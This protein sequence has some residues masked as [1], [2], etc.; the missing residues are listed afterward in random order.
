MS[1]FELEFHTTW[2]G[3]AQP[4]EGLVVSPPVLV[5]AQC[6]QKQ[7]PEMQQRLLS[8]C[9]LKKP[10]EGGSPAVTD[11]GRALSELLELSPDLFDGAEALPKELH[12]FVQEGRQ[13]LRPT[14]GL[15]RQGAPTDAPAVPT[16]EST[17]ASRAGAD[18]LMLVW[19]VPQGLDL[20]QSETK[21]GPWDYPAQAKFDRL[22]R[23]CRVPIGLLFNGEEFRLTYAP[24]GE[25]TGWLSFRV[26]D[27]CTVGGRPLL[28]AFVMLLSAFRWFGAAPDQ[29]LPALL[30]QSR[31]RQ[32]GVT[33]E[34][35]RQVF[36]ALE[37]LLAGFAAAAE[38][39]GDQVLRRALERA[40]GHVYSGLLT[41]LLRLV[42][43]LYCEDGNLL[44]TDNKLFSKHY[45]VLG[46][47]D[48]LQKD[49]GRYPDSMA[50][51]FGAY[52]RLVSL[53]R[54][55]FL[56]A[57]H[58][59]LQLPER[60]GHLFDPSEFPFLE[61]WGADGSAPIS[62]AESREATPV[63][64]VDDGTIYQVLER[65]VLLNGQ[66]LSYKA[67]DVEQIGSVY[68]ALMGFDVE[69]LVSG[70]VRIKPSSKKGAARV[71]V[72]AEALLAVPA[73]RRAKWLQDELAF[74]K[75]MANKIAKAVSKAQTPVEA[76]QAL[77][78]LSGRRPERAAAGTLVIQP[79]LERRRTSSHYTPRDFS[80]RIVART[81]EPLIQTMG[82]EP[83][84][85]SLLNLVICDPA[86]GSGA[87][88]VAACRY[89]AKHVVAAWTREAASE[90]PKLPG[91]TLDGEPKTKLQLIAD[92]HDSVDNHARR[93]VAQRCLYGVD[94]NEYAVQ[95]ARLSLWLTTMAKDEPFTFVDHALRHGDSLVGL[96][97]EQI[98]AFHWK[99]GGQWEQLET[100]SGA[101]QEALDEAIGIRQGIL[102][103]AEDASSDGQ[104]DKEQLLFDARDALRRVRLIGDLVVGAFFAHA[105][106]KDRE[107]ERN[108]RLDLVQRWLGGE[109]ELQPELEALQSELWETQ[110]PFHWMVEFPEVFYSERSDPLDRDRKN[111]AAL[112]EAFVGNPPFSGKNGITAAGG[113]H[114]LHWLQAIHEA[115]HGNADLCAHFF[116]RAHTL[117]GQHG[118]IGLIATNTV[119]QGDTRATSL[120]YLVA[121]G[122]Q[123][124]SARV[125]V[126]WPGDAA[127]TVS[128]AQLAAGSV[129]EQTQ[130]THDDE[131]VDAINSRLR[132]RP[133]RPDPTRLLSNRALSF[134]G[135]IVLGLGFTLTPEEREEL[136]QRD[137]RNAERIFPYLGG[138]EV[139]TSPTQE[140]DRYVI[141]FGQMP[142]EEAEKW[143]DLIEIVRE[144]VKPD[145]DTNNRDVRRKYWWRFGET[146]PA[147]Y[148]AIRPLSRC[149]VTAIV[150]KH[151]MFSFQPVDRVFSHKLYVFPFE[152]LANFAILQSRIHGS[153]TWLLS[154]TMKTDLNYSASDCFETFP[155]PEADP[156]ASLPE[157]ETL[158]EALYAARAQFMLDT[159]QGLTKTYNALKDPSQGPALPQDDSESAI[160]AAAQDPEHPDHILARILQLRSQHEEMDR[161]VLAAYGWSDIEV[162]PFCAASVD[163]SDLA[164]HRAA[165]QAFE[166]E[167]IDRL[168]ILNTERAAA[169]GDSS[170]SKS[171][172]KK[173]SKKKRST[174]RKPK[175]SKVGEAASKSSSTRKGNDA[176]STQ[177]KLGFE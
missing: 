59:D 62:I 167:V 78:P 87:F 106:N 161:A 113:P 12:L 21:T 35:A 18:Y 14:L 71:W 84:S 168:F 85:E 104:R 90:D 160:D 114:Y 61:G 147:L 96:S 146:T 164:A 89:L 93:M 166:D 115:A 157:L 133:E 134:Q 29:Q 15:K 159:D 31:L 42:F 53:F 151:S 10:S 19:E 125:D 91:V 139:N 103:R 25:S 77:E 165:L 112:V 33:N 174:K 40:E 153:W 140:H 24:Y 4:Y 94:K 37:I 7:G 86:M 54:A 110:T 65:L 143:P 45:S 97:F 141:S 32:S 124:Y 20:D 76:L 154:S 107:A 95:L 109:D 130:L 56:G 6:L 150:S 27:M 49:N 175:S 34:L 149:L 118:T 5:D 3:M 105:K 98:R 136:V 88:L 50:Q 80:D 11:L 158:G 176:E 111:G 177:G 38:R 108:R 39:D 70:A 156:K 148:A 52:P 28:D 138:E 92:V 75:G 47:F 55:I 30:R 2:L 83:K 81:L 121:A 135:S 60:R 23:E 99:P 69:R 116:R 36:E 144:K 57:K 74:D 122:L 79:G 1:D 173:A 66:R 64:T 13:T 26:R 102:E 162:P 17:P 123:I 67:L 152:R 58:G 126:P 120:Q 170:P 8:L 171:A 131:P 22:L 43:I 169:E 100:C 63:P 142:L 48:Q 172:K 68:E 119:G 82:P 72:S 128:I 16:A 137:K 117:L 145:R 129:R 51:R 101:L 73:S 127:V 9:G 44:P 155:F 41:V 163:P 46:L 132:P